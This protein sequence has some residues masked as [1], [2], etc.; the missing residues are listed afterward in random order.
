MIPDRLLIQIIDNR[1]QLNMLARRLFKDDYGIFGNVSLR[2]P[3]LSPAELGFLKVISW[4]YSH[5]NETGKTNVYFLVN[6][7]DTYNLDADRKIRTHLTTV[8][9]MRTY[10]QHSLN[11][12][13]KENIDVHEY[14]ELWFNDKCNVLV[15]EDDSQWSECLMYL[16][17]ESI[18]FLKTINEC[19]RKIMADESIEQIVIDWIFRRK[20]DYPDEAFDNLIKIVAADIGREY[21]DAA[22]LRKRFRDSWVNELSKLRGDINFEVECRRLI[23]HTL[24]FNFTKVLPINAT[25]IIDIFKI[26]AGKEVGRLLKEAARIYD[27]EPCCKTDLIDKLK[28]TMS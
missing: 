20:R 16:L 14:C 1:D 25:D 6:K 11:P 2:L 27:N 18:I 19:L 13:R 9:N 7:L 22:K 28:E 26:P 24:L 3:K 10:L 8:L 23:E 5:Y 17:T 12:T 4:L 15:P 21:L